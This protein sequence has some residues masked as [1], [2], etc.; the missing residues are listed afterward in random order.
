ML[1][2]SQVFVLNRG[3]SLEMLCEFSTYEFDMFDNP[4]VWK[5]LQRGDEH[6][7]NIMGNIF[8]PF[9]STNRFE[10]A[11]AADVPRFCLALHVASKSHG[12]IRGLAANLP[13]LLKQFAAVLTANGRIA[14]ATYR[15]TLAHARYC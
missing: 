14:A 8:E 5:K 11:F 7:I 15:I 4:I 12:G 13:V 6:Q 2:D 10:V 9:L 3:Q 1:S